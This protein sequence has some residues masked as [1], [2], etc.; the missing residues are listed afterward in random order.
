MVH[1]CNGAGRVGASG[2]ATYISVWCSP[3]LT[4]LQHRPH[5]AVFCAHRVRVRLFDMGLALASRSSA[6]APRILAG[7]TAGNISE[8]AGAICPGLQAKQSTP[9][10]AVQA[11]MPPSW[12]RFVHFCK[13]R[14]SGPTLSTC[15]PRRGCWPC[16]ALHGASASPGAL[17]RGRP[18]FSNSWHLRSSLTLPISRC[19]SLALL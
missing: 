10:L 17:R 5:L 9:N 7:E 13:C 11:R 3:L 4:P 19:Q 18:L 14:S 6:Q 15:W 2:T 16:C 1:C 12:P 8:M